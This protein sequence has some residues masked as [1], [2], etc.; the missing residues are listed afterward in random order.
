LRRH[1][2]F[3]PHL[4]LVAVCFFW[5]TTYL[6]IRMALESFAPLPL[7]ATRFTISGSLILVIA[8]ARGLAMPKGRDLGAICFTGVLTLGLGNCMV[9]FAETLIASGIVGLIVT[10]SPFWMV[11]ME[12]LLPGGARLHLPTIGGM[13]V[14]LTGAAMLFAPDQGPHAIDR[15][16]LTGFLMLQAGSA[17][18]S[19]GSIFQKRRTGRTHPIVIGGIQQLAA[20]LAVLPFAVAIPHH[21]VNWN[22]RGLLALCYLIVFGSMVA[23]SAYVYALGRL[24]VAMVSIHTYVN[25]VVAV[26]L[27]WLFYREPF[28]RREALAMLVIFAGVAAVKRYSPKKAAYVTASGDPSATARRPTASGNGY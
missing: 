20:G 1:P 10:I 24:P 5:G 22:T 25:C 12:A 7:V 16:L 13:A 18:W 21:P 9:V 4:A 15:N 14:G 19:F 2:L 8:A 28:G 6:G 23:Y 11:G 26:A 17:S 3:K 27:G